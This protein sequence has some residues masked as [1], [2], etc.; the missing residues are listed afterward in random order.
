MQSALYISV[1]KELVGVFAL[2]Y[3]PS[4][5]TKAG[6]NSVMHSSGLTPILATR[7]FMITPALVKKRYKVSV[8]RMEFP[9][10][11]E[12]I[13]LSAEEAGSRGRQGALMSK[14]SFL[15]FA[16]AVGSGRLLR[17]VVHS[18]VALAIFG[19][20]VGILLMAALTYLGSSAALS[21]WNLL[22]FHL[23]W[24]V[25]TLLITG[26]IGKT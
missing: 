24:S 9:V 4:P 22:L 5:D 10:V 26:M 2:T 3:Q 18:A 25:P 7:D 23:I 19:G 11:A 20:I 17:R 21:A 8:D 16:G 12:R 14:E 1:N 6:L 15:S 13:K